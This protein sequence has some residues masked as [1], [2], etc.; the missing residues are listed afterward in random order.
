MLRVRDRSPISSIAA[1]SPAP[2]CDCYSIIES[3]GKISLQSP[4]P[5]TAE[6]DG[7]CGSAS[8]LQPSSAAAAFNQTRPLRSKA[9][10]PRPYPQRGG[11]H[12]AA[13]CPYAGARI[14]CLKFAGSP[15]TQ[16]FKK[17]QVAV[18]KTGNKSP[19]QTGFVSSK[20]GHLQGNRIR[21]LRWASIRRCPIMPR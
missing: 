12:H 19:V 9:G 15:S 5:F 1:Y 10:I 13:S 2:S 18:T 20:A 21:E 17:N 7:M 8:R 16:I 11:S 14:P 4:R 6:P 3:F